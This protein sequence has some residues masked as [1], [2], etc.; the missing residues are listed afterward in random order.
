MEKDR[1]F[2]KVNWEAVGHYLPPS[3][4]SEDVE[5]LTNFKEEARRRIL[6]KEKYDYGSKFKEGLYS[7]SAYNSLDY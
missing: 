2:K 3:S 5:D 1:F 4:E 7:S 6:E